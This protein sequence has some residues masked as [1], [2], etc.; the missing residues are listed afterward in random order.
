MFDQTS[1]NFEVKYGL[2]LTWENFGILIAIMT[3]SVI[4]FIIKN[5]QSYTALKK[6]CTD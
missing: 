2:P 3:L 6:I 4:Y 1:R 5:A